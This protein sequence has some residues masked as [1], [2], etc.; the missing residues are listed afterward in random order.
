MFITSQSIQANTFT[1]KWEYQDMN[2]DAFVMFGLN[3]EGESRSI[4]LKGISPN[5]DFSFD[6]QD[7]YFI[8]I[9]PVSYNK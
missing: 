2:T 3:E 1:I 5:I 7:L 9:K 6:F 4:R 8:R